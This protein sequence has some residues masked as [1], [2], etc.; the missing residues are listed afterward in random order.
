[1]HLQPAYNQRGSSV[2][3]DTHL[4]G[5]W[6]GSSR[7][8]ASTT[9]SLGYLQTRQTSLQQHHLK[10]PFYQ[11]VRARMSEPNVSMNGNQSNMSCGS[12]DNPAAVK[13][14]QGQGIIYYH[15]IGFY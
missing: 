11:E 6:R 12:R 5:A 2:V 15:P 4:K 7:L 10:S 9:T 8:L 1:M 13:W 3:T 14:A